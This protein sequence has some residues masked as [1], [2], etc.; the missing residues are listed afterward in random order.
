MTGS[1]QFAR[2][3]AALPRAGGAIGSGH[4]LRGGGF[5][6]GSHRDRRRHNRLATNAAVAHRRP[7][8]PEPTS[9]PLTFADPKTMLDECFA[10]TGI[11]QVIG[12]GVGPALARGALI[13]LFPDWRGERVPLFAF[14]PSRKHPPAKVRA[15]IDF[16]IEIVSALP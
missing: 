16:C 1:I 11:A 3:N 9:G 10:G 14:H 15:F 6:H 8:L 13:D 5:E 4:G 12:W 7:L 2:R